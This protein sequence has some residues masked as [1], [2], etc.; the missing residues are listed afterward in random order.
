MSHDLDRSSSQVTGPVLARHW[1][2][3]Y[4]SLNLS[5]GGDRRSIVCPVAMSSIDF[6]V[7]SFEEVDENIFKYI[8]IHLLRTFILLFFLNKKYED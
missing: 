6:F 4:R 1:P 5:V 2:H 8:I 7:R 3:L